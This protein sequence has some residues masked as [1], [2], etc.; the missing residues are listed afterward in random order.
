MGEHGP[1]PSWKV[2]RSL[3]FVHPPLNDIRVVGE[4]LNSVGLGV[5]KHA[6]DATREAKLRAIHEVAGKPEG[7]WS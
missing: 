1:P 3:G 7:S 2:V 6:Q 4:A 5:L